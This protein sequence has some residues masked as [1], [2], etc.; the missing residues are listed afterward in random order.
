MARLVG[1]HIGPQASADGL[2]AGEQFGLTG[3]S[4][5]RG[6]EEREI[7][8]DS[9]IAVNVELLSPALGG[10]AARLLAFVDGGTA[11]NQLG[12]ACND[13]QTRCTLASIGLGARFTL[14]DAQGRID[15][16]RPLKDGRETLRHSTRLHFQASVSFP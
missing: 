14:G 13:T 16:A 1:P 11:R 10:S 12:T 8:G 5:V 15:L 6:Y 9:G 7:T 2:V 3:A 4:L